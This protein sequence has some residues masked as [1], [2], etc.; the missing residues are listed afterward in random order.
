MD[1]LNILHKSRR[2]L[3]TGRTSTGKS[4]LAQ[5]IIEN[6]CKDYEK[7]IVY[8]FEGEW[9]K[10]FNVPLFTTLQQ[11]GAAL[12][13]TTQRIICYDP[14]DAVS[15]D[16]FEDYNTFVFEFCKRSGVKVLALYDELQQHV[17]AYRFKPR[18]SQILLRG[19]RSQ[20][21]MIMISQQP[22]FVH[23]SV[24]S[25]VSE[26]A[27]FGQGD[28]NAIKFTEA[29]GIDRQEIMDLDDLEFIRKSV[30]SRDIQRGIITFSPK[31]VDI[32]DRAA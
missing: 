16:P 9:A 22:N 12:V 5:Y 3:I 1:T 4:S 14:I 21:D 7:V 19:R 23:N 18:F 15:D 2:V 13:S 17:D 31:G 24:R 26:I 29:F 27:V 11:T 6:E 25:Q 10:R 32:Q 28:I 30:G 8:D 20:I